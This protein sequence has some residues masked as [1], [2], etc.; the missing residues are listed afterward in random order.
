MF[1]GVSGTEAAGDALAHMEVRIAPGQAF[2]ASRES[3]GGLLMC[4]L[5]AD[6]AQE[7]QEAVAALKKG[8]VVR[9]TGVDAA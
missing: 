5:R 6:S 7:L 1:I 8:L 2:A 9:Y 4:A 3:G